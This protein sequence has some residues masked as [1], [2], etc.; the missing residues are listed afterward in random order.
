MMGYYGQP[1]LTKEV[2]DE[3]GWMHTGDLGEINEYGQVRITGRLKNLFKT[4][5]GKYINPDVIEGKFAE[6][7][8]IEN[9]VVLGENQKHAGAL[10]VPDFTFLKTWC[11]KHEIKYTNPQEM[12]NNSEVKK[13]YAEEVKKINQ[14][15]G[16]TEKIKCYELVA[17]EW[18]V[19]N[20]ILTPTL[21]VKRSVVK[22]MYKD[23]INKMYKD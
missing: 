7:G 10:I 5:L 9:I 2:I 4:S 11:Q 16:D 13:R 15:F 1:E 21:K 14:N 19:A 8:F 3:E 18:S 22:E 6:S 23:L 20:G 17:D 12:I